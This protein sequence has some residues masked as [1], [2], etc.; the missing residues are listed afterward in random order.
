MLVIQSFLTSLLLSLPSVQSPTCQD[1]GKKRSPS[2]WPSGA[3]VTSCSTSCQQKGTQQLFSKHTRMPS[4]PTTCPVVTTSEIRCSKLEIPIYIM[5]LK[6]RNSGG[7]KAM[8]I[9]NEI[10]LLMSWKSTA[11][12][13]MIPWVQ[14]SLC[15]LSA[16][17]FLCSDLSYYSNLRSAMVASQD[18]KKLIVLYYLRLPTKMSAIDKN[19][20]LCSP[21]NIPNV[22]LN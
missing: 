6:E 8:W 3:T 15:C 1:G 22:P 7:K 18:N 4:H 5:N 9:T 19:E 13:I 21:L 12:L 17:V 14:L 20:I 10:R 11:S 16:P 2:K